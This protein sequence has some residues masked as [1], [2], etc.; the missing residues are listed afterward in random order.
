ML[1]H[2]ETNRKYFL[3]ESIIFIILGFLAMA[4]PALFTY[5]VE[6][7]LGAIL[8][9]GGI[10]QAIRFFKIS[11]PKDSPSTLIMSIASIVLG[12]L[13]LVYPITGIIALTILISFLFLIQGIAQVYNG[14]QMRKLKGSTW[15]IFSG[16]ISLLLAGLI[17]SGLPGSA[18]WV[19]GLLVG[20]NMLIFGITQLFFMTSISK[21]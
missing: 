18:A 10:V 13:L 4:M 11:K 1:E 17:W 9:V 20:I 3:F 7:F 6:M 2:Y 19:I 8:L 12:L 5:S 15:I 21:R 16:I 14:L